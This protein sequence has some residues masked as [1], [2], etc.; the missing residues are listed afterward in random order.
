[1]TH[2]QSSY[3]DLP[4]DQRPPPPNDYL[5]GLGTARHT[6]NCLAHRLNAC[7]VDVFERGSGDNFSHRSTPTNCSGGHLG[8]GPFSF[9]ELRFELRNGLPAYLLGRSDPFTAAF[10][11]TSDKQIPT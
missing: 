4:V 6:T 10:G 9:R 11:R 2:A 3:Y 8:R 1:M 5:P 7:S